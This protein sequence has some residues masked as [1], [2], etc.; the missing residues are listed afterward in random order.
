M[1]K[2]KLLRV[3]VQPTIVE[4]DEQG[5]ALRVIE[6]THE[7][8]PKDWSSYSGT[9]FPKELKEFEMTLNKDVIKEE[10]LVI[11]KSRSSKND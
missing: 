6:E 2:V 9:R 3:L 4:E 10:K 1:R 7:I 8:S 11:K 5:N